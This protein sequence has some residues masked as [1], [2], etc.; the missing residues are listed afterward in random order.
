[1]NLFVD[2]VEQVAVENRTTNGM[3][4]LESSMSNLV[5]L[6]FTIGSSRG[7]DITPKFYQ[8]LAEDQTL[9]LR[10]LMW[11]RDIRGGSGERGTVRTILQSL[12]QRRPE[13]LNKLLP[14]IPEFGRWDDLLVFQTKEFKHKAFE[15]F[16]QAILAGN[17]L[18]AKWCPRKGPLAAEIRQYFGMTPKVYRKT[19]VELT[20]VVEQLMCA[21]QWQNINYN[22]VPSVAAARYQ[23]A[24]SRH[25]P[26]GYQAYKEGLA[27]GESKVNAEAV[28]PY[29]II[30]SLNHGG[31]RT[32]VQAQWDSLPCY[33]GDQL[34]LPMVDVSGSMHCQ[35]S[36]TGSLEC[37]DV[38]VSLGLYL[39]DKNTGPFKDMFLTFSEQP[40]LNILRGTLV[41][42]F[43]QMTSSDW[44][45]NTNLH[46]AFDRIL[47][48][49]KEWRVPQHHMPEYLLIL[50]DMQFDQCTEKD[51]SAM[52]MIERKYSEAGYSV[53]KIVFWNLNARAKD[54]PIKYD[55]SGAALVSGFSPAIMKSILSAESFT[56]QDVMLNTLNNP[57][58]TCIQ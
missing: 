38:A 37:L 49:A 9:A 46:A 54:V 45:M 44:G 40:Q 5:D 17:G 41:E 2:A 56:P 11:C 30:K 47:T 16:K 3:K 21:N 4:T 1:M 29:D 52:Q 24:F 36:R 14:H 12:E 6:F 50:S 33:V 48:Y 35:V 25:D 22:H 8:A 20:K 42:K 58:Y 43:D 55:Q 27:T 10:M 32:V 23:K 26:Q 19:L 34:I 31:D 51:D 53:P 15:Q 7:E 18:A 39:A 13:L 57:R 28:Y